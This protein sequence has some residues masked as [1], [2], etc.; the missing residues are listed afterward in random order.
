MSSIPSHNPG[1]PLSRGR[2]LF[3]VGLV[4]GPILSYAVLKNRQV[5]R[6]EK[7]RLLEE[8]GR[9][10][11]I[12]EQGQG[13]LRREVDGEEGDLSVSVRRSGGGV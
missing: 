12:T 1:P 5:Q 4:I 3:L 13:G 2:K 9:R 10:N 11:W 7:R 8:E 6:L